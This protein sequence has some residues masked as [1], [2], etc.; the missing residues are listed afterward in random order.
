MKI[1]DTVW[2]KRYNIHFIMCD[3]GWQFKHRADRWIAFC[4]KCGRREIIS[5]L[6]KQYVEEVGEDA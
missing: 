4:P 5:G 3:C 2:T 6:R 1:V